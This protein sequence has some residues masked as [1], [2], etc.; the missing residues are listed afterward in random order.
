MKPTVVALI[1]CY[2]EA[3][4]I[5]DVVRRARP[6]VDAVVVVDD[7]SPDAT[8]EEAR[9]AGAVVLRHERN[10]GKGAAIRTAIAH[11]QQ[12]GFDLLV[13]LDG[14]GQHDP[15]EIPK[16][17]EAQR[18]SGAAI[19]V[20]NR[21]GDVS[22][23]P[24]IRK[25]TNQFTSW[26]ISRLAGQ[27]IPD[28]QCGYRLLHRSVLTDLRFETRNFDTEPEMLIQAGRRGHRIGS[29]RVAT[30]YEGQE[31]QSKIRPGRDTIRF[32]KLVWK[33]RCR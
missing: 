4:R 25:W 16:F 12:Q 3:A 19:V 33:Y 31:K 32:L 6:H 8:A 7:G 29:V 10:Q 28:C 14:D 30:I 9:R 22:R 17:V 18:A 11:A 13:F 26:L 2:R 5:G 20:G 15:S 27:P 24:L 23:M 1:P 21:M